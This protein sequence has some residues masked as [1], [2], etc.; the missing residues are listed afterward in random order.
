VG[1]AGA[2]VEMVERALY[3]GR[4]F[5]CQPAPAAL[6][7]NPRLHRSSLGVTSF[8]ACL[9]DEPSMVIGYPA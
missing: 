1:S 4:R 8:A 5:P 9:L 6:D 2:S 3:Y 7:E